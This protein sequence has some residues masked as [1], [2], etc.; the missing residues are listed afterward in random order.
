MFH[1]ILIG[2]VKIKWIA[3]VSVVLYVVNLTGDNGGNFVPSWRCLLG[4]FYYMS[5]L[6]QGLTSP[7]VRAIFDRLFI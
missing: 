6:N 2:P 1:L 5:L 4:I 7:P 3:L